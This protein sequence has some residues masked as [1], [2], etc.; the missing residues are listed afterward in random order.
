MKI[1]WTKMKS[2]IGVYGRTSEMFLF[3]I[4]ED[5]TIVCAN[6]N[7]IKSLHLQNPRISKQNFFELLHPSNLKDFKD[8]IR[9]TH[10]INN[11]FSIDP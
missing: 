9:F 7:M 4:N 1:T 6:A 10:E 2:I 3:L 8:A 5:G 11:P